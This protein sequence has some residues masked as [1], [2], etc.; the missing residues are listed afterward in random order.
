[1][2]EYKWINHVT[3]TNDAEVKGFT[4]IEVNGVR[5]SNIGEMLRYMD[6]QRKQLTEAK[7]LL[8]KLRYHIPHLPEWDADYEDEERLRNEV[9]L[10]LKE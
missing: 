6:R 1:M 4:G 8:K 5:F 2:A 3:T 7:E 10:F 9:E